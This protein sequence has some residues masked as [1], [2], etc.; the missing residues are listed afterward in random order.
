MT[1]RRRDVLTKQTKALPSGAGSIYTTAHDLRRQSSGGHGD[2]MADVELLVSAP[3]LT[4]AQLGSGHTMKYTVQHSHDNSTFADLYTDEIIQTGAGAGAVAAT[5]RFRLPTDVYR[6]VRV[7]VT[8][9]NA[10]DASDA[11]VTA[12]LY[13]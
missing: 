12:E 6:Y 9:S 13:Y 7:K 3:A 2:H 1:F 4:N 11:S 5:K 10:N 8:A